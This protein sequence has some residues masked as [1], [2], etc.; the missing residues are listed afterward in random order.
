MILQVFQPVTVVP[1]QPLV[2]LTKLRT[3]VHL[4]SVWLITVIV[5]PQFVHLSRVLEMYRPILSTHTQ[6]LSC[7]TKKNL[8]AFFLILTYFYVLSGC[9]EGYCC[10]R[11]HSM[12]Q[13]HTHTQSLGRTPLEEEKQT[14]MYS[15]GFEPV[16]PASE[17]PQTN[18]L[19]RA[20]TGIG[21]CLL[22]KY[23]RDKKS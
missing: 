17:R 22:V 23:K 20:A 18:T 1:F 19:D 14:S 21:T 3:W 10:T 9:V 7:D 6:Y 12:T 4:P 11:S 16:I 2:Y 8:S 13:T 15:A 5:F